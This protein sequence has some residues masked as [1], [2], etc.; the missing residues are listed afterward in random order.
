MTER[1]NVAARVESAR[2]I[3]AL[4]LR[5]REAL[6]LVFGA[7]LA[8]A[9]GA[10]AAF[11]A[12]SQPSFL[13]GVASGDPTRTAVIIWTRV[14]PSSL[15]DVTVRWKVALDPAMTRV[16][17]GGATT[18][19]A[20]GDYTVKIDVDGLQPGWVYY[21]QFSA[22]DVLS[23][24]GR[25]RTLPPADYTE[26]LQFAVFSCTNFEKGYFNAYADAAR[27]PKLDAVL[28]LG[29]YNY[30]YGVGRYQTPALA[31][32]LVT[33]PRRDQLVPTTDT[34][35]LDAYRARKALYRTD[36]D[37][38]ALHAAAPWITVWDDH[39]SANDAW[40]EGAE[41]HDPATQGPW[42]ARKIAA[43]RAYYE[44]LPLREPA[45]RQRVSPTT[46]NPEHMARSFDFGRVARLVMLDTRLQHR[47]KQLTATQML[48][49]YQAAAT[50]GSFDLDRNADG[51]VRRI[52]G[53]DQEAWVDQQLST[54]TQ[55]WQVIGNQTLLQY[56][57]TP[58]IL[59]T[60]KLT[61]A[62][63]T[64]ISVV[65]DQIGGAGTAALFGTLGRLGAPNP[66]TADSW[67]GYPSARLRLY[68]SMAK[69]ANPVVVTG[70]SHNAWAANLAVPTRAGAFPIGVEFGGTSVTSP[71]YEQYFV[72]TPP[73]ALA[74]T[75]TESSQ[76]KS[77]TDKLVYADT[78][79]RGYMLMH[80]TQTMMAVDFVFV[81]TVFSQTYTVSK[82]FF[83][84]APGSKTTVLKPA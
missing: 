84:V 30:E 63:K 56:Q 27:N 72:T 3:E 36:P 43:I 65:L 38:Q 51:S 70:D 59:D 21:Y 67:N 49:V 45:D 81:N 39:E 17:R 4:E 33:E 73:R 23:T 53:A 77:T 62:Q 14:T 55:T 29:D 37:L 25:T 7:G 52:M 75:I 20:L 48:G 16:V 19:R 12:P 44:W 11:A 40:S 78:S 76:Q 31:L 82:R 5:R 35:L 80:I 1:T 10:D 6:R 8:T 68:A 28:H 2:E 50:T 22:G 71:G 64:D 46:G 15:N 58:N 69:A 54:S 9:I 74:D 18:A 79:R 47:D 61:A 26:Q 66:L 13:H 24:V 57:I 42:Q 32:G 41:N 83:T 34:V 60:T